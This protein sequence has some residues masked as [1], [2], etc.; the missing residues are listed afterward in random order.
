MTRFVS[1][2]TFYMDGM[3]RH[4][5]DFHPFPYMVSNSVKDETTTSNDN[6]IYIPA[7]KNENDHSTDVESNQSSDD[8]E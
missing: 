6:G 4:V 1:P 7:T 2:Q 8:N 5:R 3:L